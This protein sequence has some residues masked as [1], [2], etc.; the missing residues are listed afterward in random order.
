MNNAT[1]T[2]ETEAET[3]RIKIPNMPIGM[4][5]IIKSMLAKTK[6][7][8]IVC[9]DMTEDKGISISKEKLCL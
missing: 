5:M 7:N 4:G 3:K 8:V 2:K 6:G 1:H 9:T